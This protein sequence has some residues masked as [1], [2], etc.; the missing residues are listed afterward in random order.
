MRKKIFEMLLLQENKLWQLTAPGIVRKSVFEL[1]FIT[2]GFVPSS[3]WFRAI[4]WNQEFHLKSNKESICVNKPVLLYLIPFKK[5]QNIIN[6][7][8]WTFNLT[9]L[10]PNIFHFTYHRK[11]YCLNQFSRPKKNL[12]IKIFW[13]NKQFNEIVTI[14]LLLFDRT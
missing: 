6:K 11:I 4:R 13:I 7:T 12:F 2:S 3:M 1:F 10:V 14:A 9:H 5:K 8:D